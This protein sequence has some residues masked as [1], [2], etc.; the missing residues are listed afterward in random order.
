MRRHITRTLLATMAAGA[1][2]L[3]VI[4]VS[5]VSAA[6]PVTTRP[7]VTSTSIVTASQAGYVAVGQH[8]RFVTTTVV[9]PPKASYS[10]YAEVV[11]GGPRVIPA[12][13]GVRAGGGVGSVRWNVVGPITNNMAGGTMK[14]APKVGDWLT[15]SIYF[16]QKG[17]DYFT[18][19]DLT[20]KVS[21]TLNL[22]APAHVVYTAAEVACLL[23]TAPAAPKASIRLWEF[24]KSGATTYNGI[25]GS[26]LNPMWTT[27]KI[28]DV[29]PNGHVVMSPLFLWNNGRNFGAWL[30][31]P[32]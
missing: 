17:R 7:G 25:R 26:M 31:A 19:T 4:G 11:L 9:V 14:L 29:A 6:K 20:Q 27:R 22:P 12:T 8:F 21:Q 5:A 10:H 30:L 1:S 28:I 24:G 2:A 13:L 23:P 15:L 3:A 16:N 18:V 32:S